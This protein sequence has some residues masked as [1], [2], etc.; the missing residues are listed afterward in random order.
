M[1]G[2]LIKELLSLRQY[3]KIF[4]GLAVFFLLMATLYQDS[5]V[6]TAVV[7]F[8]SVIV[9][10]SSFSYDEAVHWAE[11]S[12]CFPFTR[13]NLVA[14]KYLFA[15][16]LTLG[17]SLTL[18]LVNLLVCLALGLSLASLVPSLAAA[19][20]TALILLSVIIPLIYQFGVEK[21][22]YLFTLVV[23]IPVLLFVLLGPTLESVF[24]GLS[25]LIP[26][27]VLPLGALL[28]LATAGCLPLSFGIAVR[29]FTRKDL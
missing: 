26:A 12:A 29:I 25:A 4:A 17:L 15:L 28:V 3:A 9:V 18:G 10:I 23:L 13:K 16:I 6:I 1:K 5:G 27:G 20:G 22:R 8:M 19:L 11:L 24:G 7:T 21:S 14:A 2:L